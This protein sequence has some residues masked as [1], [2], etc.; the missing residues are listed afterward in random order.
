MRVSS[1]PITT[2]ED[3]WKFTPRRLV[4]SAS[5]DDICK[6]VADATSAGLRVRAMGFGNSW[7]AH[8]VTRDVL[9]D[10]SKLNRIH[11]IDPVKK[12]VVVD[13]GVR[14]GDLTRVLAEK[15]LSLPSLSFLPDVT[16]GG[17]VATATHGT[18]PNW[19]TISDFVRSM[20]VVLASGEVRT[21]GPDSSPGEFRAA[22]VAIGM[23]GVIVRLELQV[24]D[25]PWVRFSQEQMDLQALRERLPALLAKYEHIWVHWILGE[26]QVK[27][28]LLE[29][30]TAPGQGCHPYAAIWHPSNRIVVQLLNRLGVSTS[31][32][33]QWR[34]RLVGLL[35]GKSSGG[36]L[37][38]MRGGQGQSFM[39]M[40]YAFPASQL[41]IAIDRI[42]SSTFSA[43]NPGRIVEFKFLK[44]QDL[45]YL[46][47]NSD[48]DAVGFNLWWLV[49]DAARFTVFESFEQLMKDMGAR[50]HW[51]K[52]H[53][54]P[55]IEEMRAA[56]PRWAEFEAVRARLDPTGTFSIFRPDSTTT[57]TRSDPVS[58][59]TPS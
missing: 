31:S 5:I 4:N 58:K 52:F 11:A 30:R 14:L 54:P 32:L 46:G 59:V 10:V 23:L 34:D 16:I 39:S 21:F 50:P 13:A 53:T 33:L 27:V 7:A 28:E 43:Q 41:D 2:Y 8:V 49:D 48:A 25:R 12:T 56:Y 47:P 29:K 15:N 1:P 57:A 36:T 40:Q 18:S 38:T 26:D 22:R 35:K 20:D 42:R 9:V 51:G 55:S 6:A 24:V 45:S 37:A 19:G 3:I 44:H 17:A